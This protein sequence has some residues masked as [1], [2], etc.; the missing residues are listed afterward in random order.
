M[1]QLL[2]TCINLLTQSNTAPVRIAVR[3]EGK[4]TTKNENTIDASR[5]VFEKLSD[6]RKQM[7]KRAARKYIRENPGMADVNGW[8]RRLSAR[9][10][11]ES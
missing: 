10:V 4:M 11:T 3:N 8:W 7:L 6:S 9:Q 1:F 2:A 5:E